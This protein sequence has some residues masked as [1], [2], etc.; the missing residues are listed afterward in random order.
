MHAPAPAY[1]HIQ[2]NQTDAVLCSCSGSH[3]NVELV[4][5]ESSSVNNM[6]DGVQLK[7]EGDGFPKT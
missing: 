5:Q 1:F 4:D 3:H 2:C 6:D 7:K